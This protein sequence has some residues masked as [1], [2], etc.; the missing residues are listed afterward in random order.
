MVQTVSTI[1][2]Y[3]KQKD[4]MTPKPLDT[5]TLYEKKRLFVRADMLNAKPFA[6]RA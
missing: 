6:R 2:R 1:P 3:A 5:K 4:P